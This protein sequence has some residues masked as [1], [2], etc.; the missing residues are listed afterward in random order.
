MNDERIRFVSFTIDPDHDTPGALADY[1]RRW[2]PGD[3]RWHL[4]RIS[5]PTLSHLAASLDPVAAG[6]LDSAS[7]SD[8]F[9]LIDSAGRVRGSFASADPHDMQCLL[10]TA[11][12]L[13]LW[14]G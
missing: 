6:W 10:K 9:F 8:R 12:D 7:H 4:L 14:G 11:R 2:G 13:N 5:R 1:A 3:P